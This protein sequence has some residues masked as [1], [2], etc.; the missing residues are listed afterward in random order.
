MKMGAI[1]LALLMTSNLLAA[2]KVDTVFLGEYKLLTTEEGECAETLVVNEGEGSEYALWLTYRNADNAFAGNEK[3]EDINEPLKTSND[4]CFTAGPVN[5]FCIENRKEITKYD[6]ETLTLEQFEGKKTTFSYAK[7]SY[8]KVAP[9]ENALQV[10]TLKVEKP[11]VAA[12]F[13]FTSVEVGAT[14]LSY[15]F[16]PMIKKNSVCVF[17]KQ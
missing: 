14:D 16:Y 13:L 17:D 8:T 12:A 3:F 6:P 5:P 7:Y 10:T 4:T 15:Y 11:M 2:D 1:V 9:V